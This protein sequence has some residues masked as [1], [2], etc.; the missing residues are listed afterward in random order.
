[1]IAETTRKWRCFGASSL[2]FNKF[3]PL[4]SCR[5]SNTEPASIYV[6]V[7]KG[8]AICSIAG[9]C[10]TILWRSI[11]PLFTVCVMKFPFDEVLIKNSFPQ[12]GK[13]TRGKLKIRDNI[14]GP[15]LCEIS[16]SKAWLNVVEA[17]QC[18]A[19]FGDDVFRCCWLRL[20]LLE[21]FEENEIIVEQT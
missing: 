2:T 4:Y 9:D 13:S 16:I 3:A 21:K 11:M 20:K 8:K 18:L 12:I 19:V 7:S 15:A 17:F 6:Y 5:A 1:M 14:L 10:Q